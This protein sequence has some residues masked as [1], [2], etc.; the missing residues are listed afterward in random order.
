MKINKQNILSLTL[1]MALNTSSIIADEL[2]ITLPNVP[3]A[4]AKVVSA[5]KVV[6]HNSGSE[7]SDVAEEKRKN[8]GI[9]FSKRVPPNYNKKELQ[10]NDKTSLI[11]E[12]F[13]N[14]VAAYLQAQLTSEN[15][16]ISKLKHAGFEILA[17]YPLDK[18]KKY[19][20]IVFTNKE[21]IQ[22]SSKDGRGFAATLRL[23][24]NNKNNTVN[25]N[26][27]L[28][29]MKAFMQ[30]DYDEKLAK[31]TLSSIRDSFSDIK[32]SKELIKFTFLEK[33]QFMV[34][35]PYYQDM[36]ELA[37]NS[38][39]SLLSNARKSD[40]IIYEQKL[41]NGST[42]I[43]VKLSRRTNKFVKKIGFDNGE[44]LPYPVLIENNK[45]MILAP[46][47]YIALMYP[48]LSMSEFM[49]I[50]TVP[51]AIER[52]CDKVFR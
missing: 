26:N 40:K 49:G 23:L 20:S 35:M 44:L 45:A 51:G 38:N 33:Y 24:I 29:V 48:T 37:T 27:P 16:V 15:D 12:V 10:Q 46:K 14:K 30:E 4:D 36:I 28:Y 41:D 2:H 19:V 7:N 25:I 31:A 42:T 22:A 3:K 9:V 21:M 18:K 50:A 6:V 47:Y 32:E 52:D 39:E 11:G 43:G 34:G 8:Q 5:V 13:N 1:L 17:K